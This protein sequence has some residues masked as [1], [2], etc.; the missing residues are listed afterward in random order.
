MILEDIPHLVRAVWEAHQLFPLEP[1]KAFRRHDG[2]TPYTIHP[3][4]MATTIM[5]EAELP[6]ELREKL[7][8]VALF[9]DVLEDTSFDP[10]SFLSEE[11]MR[12]VQELTFGGGSLEEKQMIWERSTEARLIKAYDKACNLLD[13]QTWMESREPGYREAYEALA[14]ALADDVQ[15]NFGDLNICVIIRAVCAPGT[16]A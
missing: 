8:R 4:W 12:L 16:V 13:G 7:C 6:V 10:R 3:L 14:L 11:E 1:E 2:R 5:L 9:H 15:R